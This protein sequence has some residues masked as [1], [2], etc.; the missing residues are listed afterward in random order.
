MAAIRLVCTVTE[1]Q[2]PAL[3]AQESSKMTALTATGN[4][5]VILD[6]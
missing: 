1:T 3:L 5:H 2:L 6:Q 4:D